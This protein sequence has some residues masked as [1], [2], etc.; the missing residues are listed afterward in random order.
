MDL[1]FEQLPF[2]HPLYIMFSS[3]TTGKPKCMVQGAG[4]VLINHLKELMLHTDLKR[5]DRIFYITILQLDDVELA[6]E[7]TGRRRHRRAVR[8]ESELSGSGAMWQLIDEEQVT[9]FGCSASYI[10]LL[11]KRG[12]SRPARNSTCHRSA[13]SRRPARRSPRRASSMSIA[14]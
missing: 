1:S 4:G 7:F 14:R 6:V 5:E 8:W 9:I 2:D 12:H 11:L 10:L 13:R 3:G